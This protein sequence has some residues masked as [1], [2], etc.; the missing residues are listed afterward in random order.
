[1]RSLLF[2]SYG[3]EIRY[4][5]IKVAILSVA[6]NLGKVKPKLRARRLTGFI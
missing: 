4:W 5:L 3:L 2:R 6:Q 1:M